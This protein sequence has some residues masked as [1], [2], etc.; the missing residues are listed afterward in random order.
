VTF[1]DLQKLIESQPNPKQ[2][3]AFQRLRDEKYWYWDVATH[4]NKERIY[5]GD[6]C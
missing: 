6:C 2:I 4:E 5:R 3:K 1:R